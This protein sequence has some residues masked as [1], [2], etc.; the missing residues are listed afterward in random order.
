MRRVERAPY[1]R[2]MNLSPDIRSMLACQRQ[3]E[4][5]DAAARHRLKAHARTGRW[6]QL[7]SRLAFFARR[8]EPSRRKERVRF[9]EPLPD[10]PCFADLMPRQAGRR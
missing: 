3:Q 8:G 4:L 5:I 10:A 2:V 9:V 1:R 7:A 6:S